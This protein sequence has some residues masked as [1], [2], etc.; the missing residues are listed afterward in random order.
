MYKYIINRPKLRNFFS[1]FIR[2]KITYLL[3]LYD[4]IHFTFI[5]LYSTAPMLYYFFSSFFRKSR[6]YKS[7]KLPWKCVNV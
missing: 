6:M 5:I 1:K 3:K 7:N 2:N 4:V